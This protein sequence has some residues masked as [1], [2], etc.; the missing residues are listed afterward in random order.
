MLLRFFAASFL[1]VLGLFPL[2]ANRAAAA[3]IHVDPVQG[4]DAGDGRSQPVKTIKRAVS[5]AQPG[6]T[7]HLTTALYHESADLHGKKGEPDKPITLDGHGAVLD[8]SEPVRAADWEALGNGLFRKL[9]LMPH[10]E[11]A[12]T[13]GAVIMRWFFLW[14]GKMN[15]MGRT[16]KGPSALLKKP[17]DLQPGEWTYVKEEDAFYLKLP[18]GQDLDAAKIRAPIR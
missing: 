9:H 2:S 1:A 6:D 4:N 5:L 7:I 12:S 3:D 8:R 11:N 14:D 18:P 15:H 10:M 13:Q 17:T 16:S